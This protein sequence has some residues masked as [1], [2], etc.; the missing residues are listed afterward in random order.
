MIYISGNHKKLASVKS[1]DFWDL[2]VSSHNGRLKCL[3][4]E[5]RSRLRSPLRGRNRIIVDGGTIEG[6]TLRPMTFHRRPSTRRFD[7]QRQ[8]LF[9]VF[10]DQRGA[11]CNQIAFQHA[12]RLIPNLL[13]LQVREF[14]ELQ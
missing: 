3:S 12:E 8:L 11:K 10:H 1:A 13:S 5:C 6:G 2:D 9:F 4:A 14:V 7:A